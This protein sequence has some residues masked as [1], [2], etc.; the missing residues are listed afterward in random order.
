MALLDSGRATTL[1][2]GRNEGRAPNW[3]L[4]GE[5]SNLVWGYLHCHL[6]VTRGPF[7][8]PVALPR[9]TATAHRRRRAATAW[10][11]AHARKCCALNLQVGYE[12]NDWRPDYIHYA[13][14]NQLINKAKYEY[15]T[16]VS[17][18]CQI[19]LMHNKDFRKYSWSVLPFATVPKVSL[20]EDNLNL[21]L[22]L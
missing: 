22:T 19:F 11:A 2:C 14:A 8:F 20:I 15:V 17:L 4:K 7:F 18:M 12:C 10:L 13:S 5:R 6:R 3:R 16:I 9:L 1:A 21:I